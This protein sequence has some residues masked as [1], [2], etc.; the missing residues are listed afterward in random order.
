MPVASDR[1]VARQAWEA[2]LDRLERDVAQSEE[3][4]RTGGDPTPVE[5]WQPP[6]LRSP[7]PDELLARARDLH[8]RQLRAR[9]PLDAALART[10]RQ[11]QRSRRSVPQP[12][13][14]AAP[15]YVD[16]SA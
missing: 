1:A 13:R 15:A 6:V 10:R 2:V 16:V 14:P 11:Q 8:E 4:A 7:L 9:A 12:A 3:M 5:P